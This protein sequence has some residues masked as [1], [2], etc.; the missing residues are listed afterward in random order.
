MLPVFLKTVS[1]GKLY[2]L[3]SCSITGTGTGS[4]FSLCVSAIYETFYPITTMKY[5]TRPTII[6]PVK[7]DIIYN[8]CLVNTV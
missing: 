2:S 1:V 8:F 6:P 7:I 5:G 3:T 4:E